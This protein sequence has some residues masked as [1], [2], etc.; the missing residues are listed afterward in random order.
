MFLPKHIEN[1]S[2]VFREIAENIDR[3]ISIDLPFRAVSTRLYQNARSKFKKPLTLLSAERLLSSVNAEHIVLIATGWPDRPHINPQIAETD[4]PPGAAS[5]GMSLHR[6]QGTVPVFLIESQLVG[7]MSV[8]ATA[9]GFKIL[10]PEEAIA[11]ARSRAPLHAASVLSFPTDPSNAKKVSEHLLNSL[12]VGA[13]IS[14]EKGG[15]NKKGIIHTS[16]GDDTTEHMA[17]I[18]I[19]VRK[20]TERSILTIGIGDGGN[21]IGMG[22][23]ARELRTWLP[24]GTVCRCDCGSGIVPVTNTDLLV[25]AAV[26][27]WGAYGIAAMIALMVGRRDVFHSPELE[28]RILKS[29]IQAGFIDGGSGYVSGGADALDMSIHMSMVELLGELVQKGIGLKQAKT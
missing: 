11:A 7:A 6:S 28:K 18:D 8:V 29:C 27:N 16:R 1:D 25:T 9:T 13:V 21:E 20:A 22:S 10:K 26:S 5:L 23:I 3:L 14:I 19:L 17:K 2:D 4:G 24:Y 12:P 15:M